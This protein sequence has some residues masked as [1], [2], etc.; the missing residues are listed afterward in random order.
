MPTVLLPSSAAPF[1]PRCSPPVVLSSTIEPWLTATLKR[2]CKAKGP[3]KNVTQ[4]MKRLKEI[5]SR[6]S[7]I[8]TLCSIMLPMVPQE[9]DAGLQY[10]TIHIEA[11]VVY[12]DMAYA[13]AVAFKLTPETINT[14]VKFYRDVY[15][16][17][18]W[19]STWEWSE[20]ENQLGKLQEQFIQDVNR[21][22]FYTDALALEGINENGAGELLG[23][24]SDVAKAKVK[25]L[26]IPLQPPY[27]EALRVLHDQ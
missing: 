2:V 17:Y 10:Q 3:L 9:L 23:G 20:K 26:F 24:R 14:L 1:A 4:H 22:I 8:W 7:A 13:N 27:P 5:L 18:A 16:V 19:H 15:S 12:V 6:P 11:Y 25:S 21:F